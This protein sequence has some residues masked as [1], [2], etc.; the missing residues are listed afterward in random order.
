VNGKPLKSYNQYWNKRKASIQSE[1]ELRNKKKSSKKLKTLSI[2]RSNYINNYLNQSVSLLIKHCIQN[3][4]GTIVCGYN[5]SWKQN[6]NLGRVNNQNFV[7]IPY[8]S[9]K[10]KLENKCKEYRINFILNEESYTSKC[11]FLDKEELKNHSEYL[12]KRIK[13]GLFRTSSGLKCNA[14]IQAAG[15]IIRKVVPSA[16]FAN[17]IEGAIVHP[18]VLNLF[19]L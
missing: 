5:E 10:R 6:L 1:L 4:I 9:F 17:G 15:N 13:R 7:N 19:N 14:D 12:G 8:Y 11:S 3:D 18:K 16:S 2:N